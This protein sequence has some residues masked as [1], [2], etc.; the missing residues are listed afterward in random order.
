MILTALVATP[1]VLLA[2]VGW[3]ILKPD[4]YRDRD[5]DQPFEASMSPGRV[6]PV[7]GYK[8]SGP[9]THDNLS[10]FLVHAPETHGDHSFLTL[11]EALAQEKAVVNE[12]GNVSQLSVENRSDEDLF[13]QAGDIVKGGKQ[14]RTLP[15]DTLIGAKSG[16]V[17]LNSFCVEQSRWKERGKESSKYF[18]SSSYSGSSDVKRAAYSKRSAQGEVWS[19]VSKT[20][21]RLGKKVG[22]SVKAEASESSLQL[23]LE[24][25]AVR[26]GVG[27]YQHALISLPDSRDDA[28]GVVV[29]VNGRVKTADVYCSR[30]LFKK[31]WPKLLENAA[32]EAFIE[33]EPGQNSQITESA[34]RSFL[35]SA[36]GG[37]PINEGVTERSYFQVRET[38][39][40]YLA[41]SCDRARENLVLHR[42]VLAR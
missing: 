40:A 39:T 12:T 37:K 32:V 11:Q 14:D 35:T 20:Q 1:A 13:I 15:Y 38:P 9:F 28:V 7:A 5:G 24:N 3:Y 25:P 19:N 29:V 36:E 18:S 16:T 26:A 41:E 42:N 30:S 10:I 8:F 34:V 33:S 4:R 21:E 23:T 17:P 22:M 2:G 31:L 6:V 27:P